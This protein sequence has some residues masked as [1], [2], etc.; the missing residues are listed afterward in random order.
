VYKNSAEA[1]LSCQIPLCFACASVLLDLHISSLYK[2][3]NL[4]VGVLFMFAFAILPL[5]HPFYLYT[6]KENT[7][8]DTSECYSKAKRHEK[9]SEVYVFSKYL[10]GSIM[11][12]VIPLAPPL[13]ALCLMIAISCV[14][15]FSASK[16]TFYT[17]FM[18][19]SRISYSL[20]HCVLHCV[21]LSIFLIDHYYKDTI[22]YSENWMLLGYVALGLIC[23]NI[24][25]D[26]T[27]II[28]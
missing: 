16:T 3:I 15:V 28:Y 10:L 7:Q 18:K 12:I 22:V 1:F 26:F 11:A 2:A 17:T 25:H 8:I 24:L 20:T 5:L 23:L 13:V 9:W 19:V 4:A 27:L 21:L 14:Q 6:V